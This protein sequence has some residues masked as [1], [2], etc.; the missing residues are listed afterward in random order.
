MKIE[1]RVPTLS[2]SVAS[3]TLLLESENT[4]LA[5]AKMEVIDVRHVRLTLVE[6]RYHQVRRMFA[7]SLTSTSTKAVPEKPNPPRGVG[8]PAGT[9]T[10]GSI[11]PAPVAMTTRRLPE[12][13]IS[14]AIRPSGSASEPAMTGEGPVM[15]TA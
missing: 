4:A 5:P 3:G 6:G 10:A 13:N 15:S 1:V 11:M 12:S 2:D 8:I 9:S 14:C 7:A